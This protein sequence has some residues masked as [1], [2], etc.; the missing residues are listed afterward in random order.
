MAAPDLQIH[1]MRLR[2][3]LDTIALVSRDDI[4]IWDWTK[5]GQFTV[6]S[7]YKDLSSFGIDRS[8]KRLWKAKIPL[9]IKVW[10][11]LIGT[12]LLLLK[13]LCERVCAPMCGFGN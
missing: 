9:K 1:I 4:P 3:L 2:D 5:N 6:K 13:I 7:I 8:F 10:L 12:M 11:Q